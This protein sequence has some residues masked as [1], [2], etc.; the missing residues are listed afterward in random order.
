[1]VGRF[2]YGNTNNHWDNFVVI[3]PIDTNFFDKITSAYNNLK[4]KLINSFS[5][6]P[7]FDDLPYS[8]IM[9]E[10]HCLEK[11]EINNVKQEKLRKAY[12]KFNISLDNEINNPE[13]HLKN[14]EKQ[15][16]QLIENE[17]NY[18]FT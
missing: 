10:N 18:K 11:K 16:E 14:I 5:K 3:Y 1:M 2:T 13:N 7:K 4:E 6:K 15:L 17:R 8:K 12:N 9:R